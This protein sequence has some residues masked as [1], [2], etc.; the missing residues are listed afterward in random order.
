MPVI[1]TLVIYLGASEA[2]DPATTVLV[3]SAQEV[4]GNAAQVTLREGP[5][6]V[7]DSELAV[8][9]PE[10]DAVA[11][12]AWLGA[13]HH[14]AQVRCYL[15]GRHRLVERDIVFDEQSA[16]RERERM[17]GFVIASMLPEGP[18]LPKQDTSLPKLPKSSPND[19]SLTRFAGPAPAERFVGMVEVAGVG[20]TGIDGSASTFG[21]SLAARWLFGKTLALRL[22]GGLR[23]GDIP[24]ASATSEVDFLS[25][26]LACETPVVKGSRFAVGGRADGLILRHAIAHLSGDDRTPDSQSRVLPGVDAL[27][28]GAWHFSPSAG[29]M[30]GVGSELAFGRTDVF[31]KGNEI[32]NIPWWRVVAELGVQAKF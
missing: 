16:P 31:V 23:K 12:I 19:L 28:E 25:L 17:L 30:A 22:G 13:D 15:G 1:V 6:G 29:L 21:V 10:A 4:L 3:R 27:V 24:A 26:G 9:A 7:S 11:N 5:D 32:T 18:D 8:L 14:R 2:A 20:A